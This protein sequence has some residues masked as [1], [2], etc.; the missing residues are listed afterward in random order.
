VSA[1]YAFCRA[2]AAGSILLLLGVLAG[3]ATPPQ[4][5]AARAQFEQ[6]NDPLEPLNRKIFTFNEYID[7]ILLKPAAQVYVV[8]I[9]KQAR[10]AMRRAL[11]NMKGPV[12][13]INNVLQGQFNRA[14]QA[15]TRMAVD[16][17]IG[18]GGLFDPAT[19]WGLD[20]QTG[21]FGQT[22]FVW[23]LPEGPYL[24]VPVLGPSNPRDVIGTA[25]DSY[26]D[27]VT[28]VADAESLSDLP[29]VRFVIDG[30]DQRARV[31]DTLDELKKNALDYYAEIRSLARQRRDAELRHGTPPPAP[32]GF[33]DV[34]GSARP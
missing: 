15:A 9:P 1:A 28:R 19:R 13:V 33:Y 8:A 16:T 5:P 26:G 21:D 14:G 6:T 22:L 27:P 4:D 31:I 25:V 2:R 24:I 10:D 3:C 23:G 18:V 34:P 30:V 11:D 32:K 7:K 12:I 20:K 29:I 17:T